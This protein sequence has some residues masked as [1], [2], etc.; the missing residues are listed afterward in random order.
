MIWRWLR[1]ALDL[2]L[3]TYRRKTVPIVKF[4][5]ECLE[6]PIDTV[7]DLDSS[8]ICDTNSHPNW[9][10]CA[11]MILTFPISTYCKKKRACQTPQSYKNSKTKLQFIALRNH[12]AGSPPTQ[13]RQAMSQRQVLCIDDPMELGRSLGASFQG[14]E[15]L[16]FEWRRA[17]DLLPLGKACRFGCQW[18][19]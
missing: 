14:F 7:L 5:Y 16:C 12:P 2:Y 11:G 9:N 10:N 6:S 13:L 19:W 3:F 8:L 15:R 1:V 17:F 4:C 18:Y